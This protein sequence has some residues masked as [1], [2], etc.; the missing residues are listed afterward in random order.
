[1]NE[2]VKGIRSDGNKKLTGD[3][4]MERLRINAAEEKEKV[5]TTPLIGILYMTKGTGEAT[6]A[7]GEITCV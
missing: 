6:E 7:Q 5:D 3:A 1:M 4:A 2:K